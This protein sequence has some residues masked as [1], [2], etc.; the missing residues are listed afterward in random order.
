MSFDAWL[1]RHRAEVEA[2]CLAV[3]QELPAYTVLPAEESLS[4]CL[5]LTEALLADQ[6][7]ALV[8]GAQQWAEREMRE[9]GATP[10]ELLAIAEGLSQAVRDLP[11]AQEDLGQLNGRVDALVEETDSG[12]CDFVKE[13]AAPLPIAVIG[14]LLGLPKEDWQLLF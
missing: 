1:H 13:V 7:E 8:E 5:S 6:P 2:R 10:S 4:T 3:V 12:E 14:W 9:R 11:L